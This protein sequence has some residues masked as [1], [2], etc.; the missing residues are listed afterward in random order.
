MSQGK[1]LNNGTLFTCINR[2]I[3]DVTYPTSYLLPHYHS[4]IY[5][6]HQQKK[7]FRYFNTVIANT[8]L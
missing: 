3:E 2:T 5:H 8:R 7:Q 1:S 4:K 6:R